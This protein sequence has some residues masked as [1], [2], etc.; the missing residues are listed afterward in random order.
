METNETR[1]G[2]YNKIIWKEKN[3]L[4]KSWKRTNSK[5]KRK[6]LIVMKKT[7]FK[8]KW[9]LSSFFKHQT[10]IQTKT[11]KKFTEYFKKEFFWKKKIEKKHTKIKWKQIK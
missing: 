11:N 1:K 6:I 9:G 7:I 4:Q 5:I 10:C 8:S 2:K 3:R